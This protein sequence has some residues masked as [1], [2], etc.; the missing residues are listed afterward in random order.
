MYTRVGYVINRKIFAAR[1]P[2]KKNSKMMESVKNKARDSKNRRTAQQKGRVRVW[3]DVNNLFA[4]KKS[5][6]RTANDH[7]IDILDALIAADPER[8]EFQLELSRAYQDRVRI[9]RD[10]KDRALVRNAFQKAKSILEALTAK[11]PTN[12]AYPFELGDMLLNL[13]RA[14]LGISTYGAALKV[15]RE[16]REKWPTVGEYQA[17]YANSLVRGVVS[18]LNSVPSKRLEEP[19]R[20]YR[21]LIEEYPAYYAYK[22]NF[23]QY[24][25][26]FATVNARAG[27]TEQAAELFSEAEACLDSISQ[28]ESEDALVIRIR[29]E[30]QAARNIN[31]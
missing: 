12:P 28:G 9:H 6:V 4:E 17:L 3:V 18:K 5:S 1:N 24:L 31:K 29:A 25:I 27:N 30:L 23:A 26:L 14:N 16:L 8:S 7:A 15:A 21:Q 20:I 22:I 2:S 13:D 11:H 10:G 19:L